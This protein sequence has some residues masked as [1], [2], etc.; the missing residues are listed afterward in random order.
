MY[1]HRRTG[2]LIL[3]IC[4]APAFVFTQNLSNA[5]EIHGNFQMDAQYYNTDS[6]IG[7]PAVPEKIL[8][9]GFLNLIYTKGNFS[10]GLRYENYLNVMQGFD[11]RYKGNGVPYRYAS[12]TQE[13]MEVTV[14][15][16]YEQFG[17]N[18]IILRSY[19]ERS[20]G[21]D[22]AFDGI[23]LKYS[24]YQ[25]VT[26]KALIADQRF[27]FDK[28]GLVRGAD[29]EFSINDIFSKCMSKIKTRFTLGG[30]VVSKYQKD[31]DPIYKLPENVAAFAGRIKV[32]RKKF[33]I[34]S[35]YAYKINDPSA[36]NN[37][38]YKPGEALIVNASVYPKK[39][40]SIMLEGKRIDNMNFRSDR[41]ATGNAL[42][43]DYL[44]AMTKQHI[45]SLAAMYP[46]ASQPN[47]EMSYQ[48]TI[49]YKIKKET[50]LGGKY[51]TDVALNYSCS[52]SIDKTKINDSTDIQQKGTLGYKSDFFKI[53]DEKYFEDFNLEVGHKFSKT[54]KTNFMF[55]NM[56]YNKEV[57]EGH[58]GTSTVYANVGVADITY[59]IQDEKSIRFELQHLYTKQ[60]EGSWAMGL[61]EY[62]T[63][64]W[65][66]AALDMY[67]YGNEIS[68]KQIH[69]YSVMIGFT[70][71]ANRIAVSYGKQRQGILCVGGVC[72][73]VPASNGIQI[74]ITSS[75]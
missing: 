48:G 72:R 58:P 38:I 59:M 65:F 15:S 9:N 34:R 67:D 63:P 41:T 2:I 46:Y 44:P 57:I 5:G 74:N 12:Y 6:T 60:D 40:M 49:R 11:P 45:Y 7:A 66:C 43:I 33:D 54:L 17:D 32:S 36:V 64:K 14:G 68:S 4:F 21:F 69:Y 50:L 71:N 31:Q 70:K 25:G 35:E 30:S 8:S 61:V 10:A 51:G 18:G 53:G 73:Q 20:L 56:I 1:I 19:E 39:G 3:L 29:G 75:F 52:N 28:A 26:L 27:F 24:P 22:N 37:F 23:K 16:F 62:T 55:A 13:G 42:I 47:G